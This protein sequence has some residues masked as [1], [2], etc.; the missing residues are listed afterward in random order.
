MLSSTLRAPM[1]Q[2]GPTPE[3]RRHATC[4]HNHAHLHWSMPGT[5]PRVRSARGQH[6]VRVRQTRRLHPFQPA[7]HLCHRSFILTLSTT[8]RRP[9]AGVQ[10]HDRT[11]RAPY[12]QSSARTSPACLHPCD[13]ASCRP[14]YLL[15]PHRTRI[16]HG[17]TQ[18]PRPHARAAPRVVACRL[19]QRKPARAPHPRQAPWPK[20]YIARNAGRP[21]DCA[22]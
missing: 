12:S 22:S 5:V 9:A 21:P 10:L 18:Q 15:H 7:R 17:P 11:L 1:P 13:H 4:C 20:W 16:P 2:G 8:G 14:P 6:Q 19:P 3:R